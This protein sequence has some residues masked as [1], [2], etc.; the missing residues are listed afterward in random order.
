MMTKRDFAR[1]AVWQQWDLHIHTPASFHW[2]GDR[3]ESDL[4]SAKSK[5]LV[6]EMIDAMNKAEPA[7]FA[8]MDYWTIGLLTAGLHCKNDSK[9]MMLQL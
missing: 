7:A 5:K 8:I 6:D 9:I 3:F 1:G 4:S 2:H